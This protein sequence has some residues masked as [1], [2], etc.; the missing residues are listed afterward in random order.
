MVSAIARLGGFP[1]RSPV[2]P[3][4]GIEAIVS[5]EIPLILQIFR[6]ENWLE[7]ER[8]GYSVLANDPVVREAVCRIIM[9]VGAQMRAS[10]TAE[11]GEYQGAPECEPGRVTAVA[12]GPAFP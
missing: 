2:P 7:S 8:R 12:I 5:H 6:D 11:M 9:R 4:P 3:T 1:A 10:I